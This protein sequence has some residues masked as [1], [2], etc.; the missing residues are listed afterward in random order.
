M[1]EQI[2]DLVIKSEDDAF[3][4]LQR[5]LANDKEIENAGIRFDGWPQITLKLEGG[6]FNELALKP[7][8]LDA[9][10]K[11][12]ESVNQAYL[13]A[14]Y[15]PDTS[16]RL[17]NAERESL[18]IIIKIHQGSSLFKIEL[19]D[20]INEIIRAISQMTSRDLA[21]TIASTALI[22]GGTVTSINYFNNKKEERLAL[23]H[24][25]EIIAHLQT[26]Q[27][28]S[29]EETKRVQ[30]IADAMSENPRLALIEEKVSEMHKEMLNAVSDADEG[31]EINGIAITPEAGEELAKSKRQKSAVGR[32]DG[33]YKVVNVNSKDSDNFRV[34]VINAQNKK[35]F[36]A[37]VRDE[38]SNDSIKKE[39]QK[40]EWSRSLVTLKIE[41]KVVGDTVR[42]AT[43]TG[44]SEFTPPN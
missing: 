43:I 34:Q 16:H 4:L 33:A 29:Q 24:S 41:A 27:V 39:L 15:G 17:N 28:M 3:S 21:I 37:K 23:A 44:A 19:G 12:Q 1:A 20:Q 30:I 8:T 13:L 6:A 31:G 2:N 42:D 7:S 5:A 9:L 36:T 35:T 14:K 26:T 32:L 18:A 10:I 22:V 40:A 38:T 25:E 11:I